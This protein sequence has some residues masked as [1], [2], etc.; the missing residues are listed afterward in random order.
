[1][2]HSVASIDLPTLDFEDLEVGMSYWFKVPRI[3]NHAGEYEA[4]ILA[5]RVFDGG[6]KQKLYKV[7]VDIQL[8]FYIWVLD[9]D[10]YGNLTQMCTIRYLT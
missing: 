2:T 3:L 10:Q 8:G 4:K 1:M 5:K 6:Y 9:E 7:L